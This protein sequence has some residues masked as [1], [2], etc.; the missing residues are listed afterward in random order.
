M[1]VNEKDGFMRS[2]YDAVKAL[3]LT[4]L[5]AACGLNEERARSSTA[6]TA[7]EAGRETPEVLA[8]S[9]PQE[10]PA[11]EQ[12][13][14]ADPCAGAT[15][16]GTYKGYTCEDTHN[17]IIA[18]GIS[19]QDTRRKCR[20]NAEAN[21]SLSFYCTWN[22]RPAYRKDTQVGACSSLVCQTSSATA[23]RVVYFCESPTNIYPAIATDNVS[24]QYA[25]D[26]CVHNANLNPHRNVFCTWGDA[27]LF[28]RELVTG[29]CGGPSSL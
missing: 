18:E 20:L 12:S 9:S 19:C 27:E 8:R 15:G 21:P 3:A 25:L 4:A 1:R 23:R 10:F 28:R 29:S 26:S 14:L 7:R 17:F 6:E 13:L 16:P 24:C 11:T 2:L 22:D 5:V